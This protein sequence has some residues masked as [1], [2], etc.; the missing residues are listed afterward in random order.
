MKSAHDWT[1]RRKQWLGGLMRVAVCAILV[2]LVVRQVQWEDGARTADGKIWPVISMGEDS[3]LVK[4]GEET[5]RLEWDEIEDIQPGLATVVTS[6]SWSFGV[7]ALAL[8]L[9]IPLIAAARWQMIL[10]AMGASVSPKV[11]FRVTLQHYLLNLVALGTAGGDLYRAA[12]LRSDSGSWSRVIASLL[13]DRCAGLVAM[14]AVAGGGSVF[15]LGDAQLRQMAGITLATCLVGVVG[16]S[17]MWYTLRSPWAAGW[18]SLSRPV[19]DR[20]EDRGDVSGTTRRLLGR[21]RDLMFRLADAMRMASGDYRAL[22]RVAL[23]ALLGQALLVGSVMYLAAAV[24]IEHAFAAAAVAVPA[25]ATVALVVP[26][27]Q[28]IGA[29]EWGLVTLLSPFEEGGAN[30]CLTLALGFRLIMFWW[31]VP[32]LVMAVWPGVA[33]TKGVSHDTTRSGAVRDRG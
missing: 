31:S 33:S 14:A 7:T 15:L 4:R 12:M 2:T 32:G 16:A 25:A 23:L 13:L 3:A 19:G 6:A 10:Q 18:M 1:D 30:A 9:P 21:V 11:V 8:A 24:G 20:A 29:F 17:L 28:G 5:A 26:T 22:C 27:P